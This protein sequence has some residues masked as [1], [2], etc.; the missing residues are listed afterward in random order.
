MSRNDERRAISPVA[1][2]ILAQQSVGL[3][4]E[5]P[6]VVAAQANGHLAE[7]RATASARNGQAQVAQ[8][9]QNLDYQGQYK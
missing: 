9:V 1:S 4:P 3:N 7:A 8:Q 6:V 5:H 2:R